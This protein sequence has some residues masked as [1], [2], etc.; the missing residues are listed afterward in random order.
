M[1][2]FK[3]IPE[4]ELVVQILKGDITLDAFL[5][6][7]GRL[8]SDSRFDPAFSSVMDFRQGRILMS[9]DDL[10]SAAERFRAMDCCKGRRALLVNRS[11][12]TAKILIFRRHAGVGERFSVYSTVE[13]AST[14]LFNDLSRF[15]EEEVIREDLYIDP[16]SG[17]TRSSDLHRGPRNPS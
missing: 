5:S 12:D 1:H 6:G 15:L 4:E 9:L 10:K 11:V 14:F 2:S 13:G 8:T 17:G 16:Q 3:I 7:M